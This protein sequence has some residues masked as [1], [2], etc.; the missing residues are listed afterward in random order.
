MTPDRLEIR[1]ELYQRAIGHI[2]PVSSPRVAE[3][4]KILEKHVPFGKH[5]FNQ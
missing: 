1:M 5:Q 3:M 2:Y 4:V